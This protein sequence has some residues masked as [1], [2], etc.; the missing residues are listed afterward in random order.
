MH[1]I[2]QTSEHWNCDSGV[3]RD[4]DT[5]A[6]SI[7]TQSFCHD[8]EDQSHHT[9]H[10]T[11]PPRLNV[12]CFTRSMPLR[13]QP[14][15][16]WSVRPATR[17]SVSQYRSYSDSKTSGA[18]DRSAKVDAKPEDHV[19]QEAAKTAEIMGEQGP[20]L[21]RGTP[22]E[23]IV[24]NDKDAQE[25][26]PKVMKDKLKANANA[27]PKGSRSY[28]TM[29]TQTS[30]QG[31]DMGL[32]DVQS[33][34]KLPQIP[35]LKFEMPTLPL[36][37]DGHV[38]RRYDPVVEQ[39]T[40]LLMR[41]GEKS[42]AQ[43]NMARILQHLRTS[44]IPTINPAKP[45]LPGAP[46]P[47]HLP[48]NP[49]LYLTLAID[50]VA[51]LMRIRSQRGAAGGGVALQIPVPMHLRQRR[52]TAIEWIMSNA[53][54]RRNVGSGKGSFAQRIAQ[55]LIAVVEGRSTV[56][57]RRNALHKLGVAA[58]ANIVLPKKR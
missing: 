19:S 18:N 33:A 35:G 26:L 31:L 14:R 55:E 23:D 15:L 43:S 13:P 57:D 50:S 16:Q 1:A 46:P 22:V 49:I 52:R 10:N 47:S 12:K 41:H 30:S 34:A 53:S 44:P 29:T 27:A 8:V 20:D 42:V 6:S 38:K 28:S 56:W 24:K 3:A 54:K 51:P 40:N 45:L 9:P 48:L 36:P 4:H 32:V 25:K 58:R 2:S 39:V 5:S 11:M 7:E 17:F 21:S 37:K